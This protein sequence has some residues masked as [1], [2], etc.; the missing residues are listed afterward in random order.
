MALWPTEPWQ[1]HLGVP[2]AGRGYCSPIVCGQ[3]GLV[4]TRASLPLQHAFLSFLATSEGR[5]K[6]PSRK[7]P[8]SWGGAAAESHRFLVHQQEECVVLSLSDFSF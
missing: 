4:V 1:S 3:P 5:Q 7:T 8:S 2:Q 6:S